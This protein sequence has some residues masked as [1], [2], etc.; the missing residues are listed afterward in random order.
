MV[1]FT[2]LSYVA[3]DTWYICID[4]EGLED[5]LTEAYFTLKSSLDEDPVIQV[6]L[7]SGIEPDPDRTGIYIVRVDQADT[8]I[9]AGDYFYDIHVTASGDA[10]TVLIGRVKVIEGV[11]R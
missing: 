5:P 11:T 9:A 4:M 6:S 1:D 7:G 2:P 10:Q 3:G 8:L